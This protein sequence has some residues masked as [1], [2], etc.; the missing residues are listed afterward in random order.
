MIN[1]IYRIYNKMKMTYRYVIF[2]NVCLAVLKK[3]E[4]VQIFYM[5][6]RTDGRITEK[7]V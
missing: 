4:N 5:D 1:T 7:R 3:V 6:D 2:V